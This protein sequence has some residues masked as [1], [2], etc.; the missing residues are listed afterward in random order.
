M[1]GGEVGGILSRVSGETPLSRG[2]RSLVEER[3]A[4]M[5][6]RVVSCAARAFASPKNKE[7][8]GGNPVTIYLPST[9]TT[10]NERIKLAQTCSW[11][12]VVIENN[13]TDASI[14]GCSLPTFH[15]YMPSGEEVSF[16]GRELFYILCVLYVYSI[17]KKKSQLSE[18]C[19]IIS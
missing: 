9:S 2:G 16:C 15:F 12:S 17:P 5:A 8:V 10:S 7:G 13:G 14:D 4:I 18:M 3:K 11:E 6:K 19:C 1:C